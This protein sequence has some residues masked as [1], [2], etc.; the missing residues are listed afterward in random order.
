MLRAR[1][2]VVLFLVWSVYVWVTRIVN[3]LGDDEANRPVALVLALSVL[4]PA[5]A[6][7]A[8][9]VQARAR[10]FSA[11]EVRLLDAVAGWT[12]LVWLVRGVEIVVS[13]HAADFKIVHVLLGVISVVLAAATVRVARRNEAPADAGGGRSSVV[14]A[15]R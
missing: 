13:D 5:V 8:V 10:A 3:A 7:G 1:W 15:D 2:P 9:L 4:V 14:G 11:T 12:A 6:T